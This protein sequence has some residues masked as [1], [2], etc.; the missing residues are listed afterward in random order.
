MAMGRNAE[1][2]TLLLRAGCISS[3]RFCRFEGPHALCN[4]NVEAPYWALGGLGGTLLNEG[5][6]GIAAEKGGA[7]AAE[8]GRPNPIPTDICLGIIEAGGGAMGR[9]G[10]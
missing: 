5:I 2:A 1:C 7:A 6:E 4:G 3:G 8:A 10:V 9:L